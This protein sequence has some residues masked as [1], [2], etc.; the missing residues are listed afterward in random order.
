M[1]G[2]ISR[3]MRGTS[4]LHD[5]FKLVSGT[6]IVQIV[7]ILFSPVQSRLYPPETY[8]SFALFNSVTSILGVMACLRYEMAI[9]IPKEREDA[10]NLLVLSIVSSIIF[11]V[12]V[13]LGGFLSVTLFEF[14][15]GEDWF[16]L[17]IFIPISVLFTG[18][19]NSLSYWN[20]RTRNFFRISKVK[21]IGVFL[22]VG[23]KLAFGVVGRIESSS[24]IIAQIG[25][26]IA[27]TCILFILILEQ[28]WVF[29]KNS[30]KINAIKSTAKVYKRFPL[31][32]MWSTLLN[33]VSWQLPAIMLNFFFNPAVVGYY[34]MAYT[35]LKLP[36][37]FIGQSVSQVFFQRSVV[38]RQNDKL[39]VLVEGIVEKMIIFGLFPFLVL[40]VNGKDIFSLVFGSQWAE[41][42][43]YVQILSIWTFFWFVSSPLSNIYLVLEKHKE[44]FVFN[45]YL[46]VS[47]FASLFIGGI[48]NNARLSMVLF[49]IS[50]VFIYAYMFYS[51]LC[52]SGS[53]VKRIIRKTWKKY[54]IIAVLI[55]ILAIIN[56]NVRNIPM[57]IIACSLSGLCYYA[58]L[59]KELVISYRG[60]KCN[61]SE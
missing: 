15:K 26:V 40:L 27:S 38:A 48:L 17:I 56:F 41:A 3:L 1:F 16:N 61:R 19:L 2:K 47:R 52:M 31:V 22:L 55:L 32:Q 13:G 46:L 39:S 11:S 20:T 10:A 60:M 44:L 29:F 4:F 33:T 12:F 25:S 53:S 50:G 18:I 57:R 49:S 35:T 6:V 23:I 24:L 45:I 54:I 7:T 59:F 51:I 5:V 37:S 28:D 14:G 21:V 9:L 58:C 36:M 42:G 30:I 34:T 8:G 43:V